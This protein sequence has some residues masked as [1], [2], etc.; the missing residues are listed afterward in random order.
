MAKVMALGEIMCRLSVG[1]G[2]RLSDAPAFDAR[3]GGAEANVAVSLANFGHDANF[4]SKVPAGPLGDAAEKSLRRAGVGLSQ[5]LRGGARLGTYYLEMG[6]ANR[7]SVAVYDRA[8]S[9]F[10]T[11]EGCEWDPDALF[12]GVDL[13]HI[14]GICPALSP[15]WR[16]L[17]LALM[18]EATSRNVPVSYDVN[19]RGKLWSWDEC[20][21][22]FRAALPYVTVLSASWGDAQSVLGLER[23]SWSEEAMRASYD[24][25][26]AAH[27]NVKV[28]YSTRRVA[29]SSSSNDLTGYLYLAGEDGAPGTL[30][31][32]RTHAIEPIVDRVGGGDAFAAGVLHGWLTGMEPQE[33]IEFAA[34]ASVLKHSVFGDANVFT[35]SEVADFMA[36]GSDVKR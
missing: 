20:M 26:V 1:N 12:D 9:S 16:T 34:A 2:V 25:L 21:D 14:T 31:R 15:T 33:T 35:A 32:S 18:E 6:T 19:F 5:L 4:A 11:M 28:I 36:S 29:H 10:A 17:A 13:F 27:P 8:G 24:A 22:S 23:T 3:Y 7:G 30:V